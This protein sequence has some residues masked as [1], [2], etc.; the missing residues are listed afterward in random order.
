MKKI[1]ALLL[2]VTLLLAA[3]PTAVFATASTAAKYDVSLVDAEKI[4]VSGGTVGADAATEGQHYRVNL[5]AKDSTKILGYVNI[6]L[7]T[8]NYLYGDYDYDCVTGDLFIY[9]SSIVDD[10]IIE[11]EF[12]D[13]PVGELST[14]TK[15]NAPYSGMFSFTGASCIFDLARADTYYTHIFKLE[16]A[17]G[18]QLDIEL[19]GKYD[20]SADS[21]FSVY[22]LNSAGRLEIVKYQD[23]DNFFPGDTDADIYGEKGE[24]KIYCSGTYYIFAMAYNSDRTAE[25]QFNVS[26]TKNAFDINEMTPSAT[27]D[28]TNENNL[29]VATEADL[30]SWDSDTKTLTLKDGFSMLVFGDAILLPTGAKLVVEGKAQIICYENAVTFF[31]VF[32]SYNNILSSEIR[33]I[34]GAKLNIESS[35]GYGIYSKESNLSIIGELD[36]AG[37]LPSVNAECE[38]GII[39]DYGDL[40]IENCDIFLDCTV[41]GICGYEGNMTFKSSKLK[42]NSYYNG[43]FAESGSIFAENDTDAKAVTMTDCDIDISTEKDVGIFL[44]IDD[45]DLIFTRC[46][47]KIISYDEAIENIHGKT[48]FT[49]CDTYLFSE[50]EEGIDSKGDIIASGGRMV[51]ISEENTLESGNGKISLDK[52]NFYLERKDNY[53]IIDPDSSEFSLPGKFKALD[54]DGNVIYVGE[55]SSDM[56]DTDRYTIEINGTQPWVIYSVVEDG[57]AADASVI[58]LKSEYTRGDTAS[59]TAI[60]GV[61]EYFIHETVGYIPTNWEI[62]GQSVSGTWGNKAESYDA[63]F[64]TEN[65]APGT[66]TLKVTFKK[67]QYSVYDGWLPLSGVELNPDALNSANSDETVT[68]S[69]EFK[70]SEKKITTNDTNKN[71]AANQK[72]SPLTADGSHIPAIS[73]VMLLAALAVIVYRKRIYVK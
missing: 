53:D 23:S 13:N 11:P 70:V 60:P 34:A 7:N 18:D 19:Y 6:R 4:T 24:G 26:V 3:L 68:L 47:I 56:F 2:A 64:T 58:N 73:S 31:S 65:L 9:A 8:G 49:D 29:P 54:K 44:A 33:L 30:W 43:I 40:N 41:V 22:Y 67:L 51:I 25:F 10:I 17:K 42:I 61:D 20:P 66:Y 57:K 39:A 14:A 59:F 38:Y 32:A 15:I 5:K 12:Y 35:Y 72:T 50:E 71:D 69:Y 46:R 62:A 37:S 28:F 63:S 27:L 16:L 36:A 45:V 52:L 1:I 48:T 21:M 55:W